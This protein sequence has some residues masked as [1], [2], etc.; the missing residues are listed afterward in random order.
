MLVCVVPGLVTWNMGV[1]A[2]FILL[3]W[4]TTPCCEMQL[5]CDKARCLWSEYMKEDALSVVRSTK[6]LP[7]ARHGLYSAVLWTAERN[8]D[9]RQM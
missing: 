7:A 4:T 3:H 6:A 5:R 1:V 2:Y 9:G 8:Q